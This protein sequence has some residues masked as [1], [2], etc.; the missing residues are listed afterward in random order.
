ME[1]YSKLLDMDNAFWKRAKFRL[2]YV[3]GKKYLPHPEGLIVQVVTVVQS[4][5]GGE[6]DRGENSVLLSIKTGE[7]KQIKLKMSSAQAISYSWR[8]EFRVNRLN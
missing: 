6:T 7:V 4:N 2:S 5:L 8:Q 3:G 1:E